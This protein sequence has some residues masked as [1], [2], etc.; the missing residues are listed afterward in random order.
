MMV[1]CS[2]GCR[3]GEALGDGELGGQVLG[4]TSVSTFGPHHQNHTQIFLSEQ[5]KI[6]NFVII[7]GNWVPFASAS[8][9]SFLNTYYLK[10]HTTHRHTALPDMNRGTR[11]AGRGRAGAAG[12]SSRSTPVESANA[13]PTSG[14]TPSAT[15]GRT[16][17]PTRS[18]RAASAITG[19]FRPKNI[20]RDEAERDSIARQEEKKAS[21]KVA[22]ERRARG[23]GRFRSKRSRG[24]AMGRGRGGYAV[25]AA[26]GP[27]S[28]GFAGLS[29]LYFEGRDY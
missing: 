15:P 12:G 7:Y 27:F 20:R 2:A 26:A 23:R 24:D 29:T 1:V 14:R 19:R 18:S 10:A 17:G 25:A 11:G 28:G 6:R 9:S 16:I 13:T 8:S 5:T 4:G 3:P 22:E 21:D